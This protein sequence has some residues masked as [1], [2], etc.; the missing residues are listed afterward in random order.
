MGQKSESSHT[1]KHKCNEQAKIN[2]S[3]NNQI[4]LPRYYAVQSKSCREQTML[5]CYI[6]DKFLKYCQKSLRQAGMW[7]SKQARQKPAHPVANNTS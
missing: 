2:A 7:R 5:R 6:C 3:Q 4:L 1:R